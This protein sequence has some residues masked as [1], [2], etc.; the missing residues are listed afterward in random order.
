MLDSANNVAAPRIVFLDRAT[1]G[2]TIALRAPNIP[3]VWVD[4][5]RSTPEQV[6]ERLRGA[7]I[8]VTN[9]V[10]IDA[11]ALAQLP[12]LRL[13]AVAATGT[14]VIDKAAAAAQGVLVRNVVGYGATS[15]SEH[16]LMLILA[17]ARGLVPHRDCVVDGSWTAGGL[18]CLFAA[19]VR[20]LSQ[21]R[22]GLIGGGQI[23]QAVADR[24]KALGMDVVVAERRGAAPRDGRLSFED[25]MATSDI[26]SLHCPLTDETRGIINAETLAAAKRGIFIINTARGALIDEAALEAALESGQVGGAGLDVAIVEPPALDAP[27]LR[28]AKRPEVI[29][30]PHAAWTSDTAMA[31]LTEQLIRNIEAPLPEAAAA[32]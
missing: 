30:T 1:L 12:D 17:M 31:T 14:D 4:H 7:T 13:I 27:I 28:L 9:K 26:V 21:M 24:A 23:A 8:A 25:V 20:D 2:P 6:V 15:V 3:H 18:F 11:A 16:V 19:P 29:V 5:E 32:A 10:P 22:L